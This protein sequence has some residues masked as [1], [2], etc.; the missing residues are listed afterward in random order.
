M[1]FLYFRKT[2][3][4]LLTDAN[5]VK[6]YL[7]W[8]TVHPS[9]AAHFAC[10]SNVNFSPTSHQQTTLSW[11]NKTYEAISETSTRG[12]V[13]VPAQTMRRKTRSKTC[14]YLASSIYT[15]ALPA[16]LALWRYTVY[17]TLCFTSCFLFSVGLGLVAII[18]RLLHHLSVILV[19]RV[20]C[21]VCWFFLESVE[22]TKLA[23]DVL[24][25]QRR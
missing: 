12:V 2:S 16:C 13:H 14:F 25:Y 11:T 15:I 19:W 21:F 24:Y 10:K 18:E 5:F 20:C 8:S 6:F 3:P 1:V 7:C 4:R 17:F 23:D 9:M 22:V